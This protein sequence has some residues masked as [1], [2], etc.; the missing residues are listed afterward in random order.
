MADEEEEVAEEQESQTDESPE[1]SNKKFDI[2]KLK[3]KFK[4]IDWRDK[5]VMGVVAAVVLLLIIIIL[6]SMGGSEEE[7]D[8]DSETAVN[9]EDLQRPIDYVMVFGADPKETELRAT[10]KEDDRVLQFSMSLGI[11]QKPLRLEI[12]KR[13]A[14]ITSEVLRFF[15]KMTK[16]EVLELIQETEGK[17]RQKLLM[18]INGVLQNSG[19]ERLDLRKSGRIVSLSFTKYYFPSI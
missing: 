6:F 11:E 4:S 17:P 15:S 8:K 5:K 14:P 2:E 12:V 1:Q 3:E 19:Q 10:I 7:A 16:A 13:M 9:F 18:A